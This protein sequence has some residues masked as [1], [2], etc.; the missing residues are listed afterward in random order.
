MR[1]HIN[2]MAKGILS[3]EETFSIKPMAIPLLMVVGVVGVIGGTLLELRTSQVLEK[4]LQ[5]LTV[6]HQQLQNDIAILNNEISAQEGTKQD[7]LPVIQQRLKQVEALLHSRVL[8]SEVLR[9]IS[10][11]VPKGIYL[12]KFETTEGRIPGQVSNP[13]AKGLRF[14]G[15]ARSHDQIAFF[16]AALEQSRR[17]T[18]VFLVY[19]E[20]NSDLSRPGVGFELVGHWVEEPIKS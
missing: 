13:D 20:R 8:W 15:S 18:D 17:F 10:L 19:A 16:I 3:Q 11:L 6:N 5:S 4:E 9:Q 2:L 7:Q 1:Q 12:T 14:V